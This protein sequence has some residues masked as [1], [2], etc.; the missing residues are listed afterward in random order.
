M[1][2]AEDALSR[3]PP[4]PSWLSKD[5]KAEWRRVMPTLCARRTLTP[6]DL[7]T[8]ENYCVAI[9]HAREIE[10]EIQKSDTLNGTLFRLQDK[11]MQTARQLA[12]ELGLTPT[13]RNRPA[14]HGNDDEH[15][16]DA[17]LGV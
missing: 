11:T 6:A 13:S 5:A 2:P 4:V 7:G 16:D 15:A 1:R 17:D 10:R 3:A 8:A 12:A 14:M 9:G